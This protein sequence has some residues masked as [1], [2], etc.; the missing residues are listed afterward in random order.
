MQANHA[1][2]TG[3]IIRD[4][5][6]M[7]DGRSGGTWVQSEDMSGKS[8]GCSCLR[9]LGTDK[10][11]DDNPVARAGW[12]AILKGQG[13]VITLRTLS[14]ERGTYL[15]GDVPCSLPTD[16]SLLNHITYGLF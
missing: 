6:K 7:S 16:T 10:G 14:H 11:Y 1:A 8:Q 9:V 4:L 5:I 15:A 3:R 13:T 12:H 2:I